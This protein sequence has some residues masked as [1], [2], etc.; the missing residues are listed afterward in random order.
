MFN[1]GDQFSIRKVLIGL[2]QNGRGKGDLLTGRKQPRFW[3]NQQQETCFSWNNKNAD[4]GQ[5]LRYGNNVV[6]TQHK[7]SDY[8]NLGAGLP[9]NQIPTQVT[10]AYP[11]GV[12]G[13][14]AYT[15]EYVYPHPLVTG[16]PTPTINRH[17]PEHVVHA[18][19]DALNTQQKA[20]NG[21]RILILGLAGTAQ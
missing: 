3:P 14:S 4:T 8:V 13:G 17:M 18:V 6:P 19:A 10:A 2:D 15:Q 12:N 16:G 9:A 1:A 20:I 11:P 5:V 21:S 7:G